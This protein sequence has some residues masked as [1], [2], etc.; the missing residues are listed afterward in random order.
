MYL[1]KNYYYLNT[2]TG[3]SKPYIFFFHVQILTLEQFKFLKILF[4]SKNLTSFILNIKHLTKLIK[5]FLINTFKGN[6]L[7]SSMDKLTLFIEII[8]LLNIKNIPYLTLSNYIFINYNYTYINLYNKLCNS[9]F[10]LYYIIW[11]NV[12]I[13]LVNIMFI[14]INILKKVFNANAYK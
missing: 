13:I 5:N 3:F 10:L 2:Y 14:Y 6:C 1:A 4:L 8:S 11:L 7:V 12:I 9:Y